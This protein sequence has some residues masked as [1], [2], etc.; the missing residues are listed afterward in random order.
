MRAGGDDPVLVMMPADHLIADLEAVACEEAHRRVPVHGFRDQFIGF[1]GASITVLSG[2][3]VL[4][5]LVTLCA[6]II[7]VVLPF[8][9]FS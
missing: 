3:G 5:A 1:V 9:L 6:V 7:G 8:G 4:G 2:L